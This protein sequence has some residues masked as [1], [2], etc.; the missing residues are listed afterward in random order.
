MGDDVKKR[1]IEKASSTIDDTCN[2]GKINTLKGFLQCTKECIK[3]SCCFTSNDDDNCAL[4][5]K[6]VCAGY[7]A[8]SN[9]QYIPQQQLELSLST[10]ANIDDAS[11]SQTA[12]EIPPSPQVVQEEHH[13]VSIS[14]DDACQNNNNMNLC[15]DMCQVASCCFTSN[16]CSNDS[17]LNCID[18][19][20]CQILHQQ[21][22]NTAG[23]STASITAAT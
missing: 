21:Q 18:Y 23:V 19:Q 10:T 11:N 5:K 13:S 12:A 3:G 1:T 14:L 22:D 8:C 17:N 7:S 4:E 9:I 20:P 6:D 15:Q 2:S 16:G